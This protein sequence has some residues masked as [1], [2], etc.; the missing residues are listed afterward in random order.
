M[1][2]P[3]TYKSR[4][5]KVQAIEFVAPAQPVHGGNVAEIQA[6]GAQ[7]Q[8]TGHWGE[9]E[10]NLELWVEKAD[11]WIDIKPGD[12]II[13]EPDGSGFYPCARE[14]F[15]QRWEEVLIDHD[16]AKAIGDRIGEGLLS[17]RDA[18]QS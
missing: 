14:I 18:Q 12:F 10:Y 13:K 11:K 15:Q 9:G 2:T 17:K 8:P 4:P 6:W 7:V 1:D 3:R 5:S 16:G